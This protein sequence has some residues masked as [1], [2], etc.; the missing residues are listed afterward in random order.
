MDKRKV[1]KVLVLSQA[2]FFFSNKGFEEKMLHEPLPV[3]LGSPPSSR[4]RAAGSWLAGRV[5]SVR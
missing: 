2:L 1:F 3:F 4:R 5:F